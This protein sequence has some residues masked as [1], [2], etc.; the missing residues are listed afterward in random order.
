M[1]LIY[2][3]SHEVVS[4]TQLVTVQLRA[5]STKKVLLPDRGSAIVIE[6]LPASDS[7]TS[8]RGVQSRP[9]TRRL[10]VFVVRTPLGS[11]DALDDAD[12][13]IVQSSKC[14]PLQRDVIRAALDDWSRSSSP[15]A[16]LTHSA[17]SE[18]DLLPQRR[19]LTDLHGWRAERLGARP[20]HNPDN[21][22]HDHRLAALSREHHERLTVP[23][24][25]KLRSRSG[26]THAQEFRTRGGCQRTTRFAE[27]MWNSPETLQLTLLTYFYSS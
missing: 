7:P 24:W 4:T 16:I 5:A 21:S 15:A 25:R 26:P 2:G 14:L 6:G 18:L 17:E 10:R 1:N 12:R 9:F 11:R 23:Q 13:V 27:F 3:L 19:T 8:K 20:Q 22:Q